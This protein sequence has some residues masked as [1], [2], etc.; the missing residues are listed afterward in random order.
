[1][2]LK[3]AIRF[4]HRPNNPR[5]N[6]GR[7]HQLV[8]KQ[9]TAKEAVSSLQRMYVTPDDILAQV[10]PFLHPGYLDTDLVP[11]QHARSEAFS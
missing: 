11:N 1:M 6:L 4:F 2:K 9:S 3:D 7:H 10:W 5:R 8:K